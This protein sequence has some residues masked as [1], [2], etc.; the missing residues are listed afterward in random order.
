M[1]A[2]RSQCLA[3]GETKHTKEMNFS[4]ETVNLSNLFDLFYMYFVVKIW[5]KICSKQIC[6]ECVSSL[7]EIWLEK[8]CKRDS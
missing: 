1:K 3:K 6:F 5:N 4:K 2:R 7:N 8:K